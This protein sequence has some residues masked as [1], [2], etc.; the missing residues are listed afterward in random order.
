MKRMLLVLA[1]A[2]LMAVMLVVMAVPA[3]AQKPDFLCGEEFT[4]PKT[5]TG[6]HGNKPIVL[7]FESNAPCDH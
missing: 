3:L 2:A 5:S 6:N 4:G 7:A 1:M